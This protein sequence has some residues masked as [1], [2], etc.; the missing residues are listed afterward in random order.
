MRI[1]FRGVVH[2]TSLAKSLKRELAGHGHAVGIRTCENLVAAMAGY[3]TWHEL[4]AVCGRHPEASPSDE[5]VGAAAAAARRDQ[6]ASVLAARFGEATALSVVDAIRPTGTRAPSPAPRHAVVPYGNAAFAADRAG[7]GVPFV[8]PRPAEKVEDGCAAVAGHLAGRLLAVLEMDPSVSSIVP[9]PVAVNVAQGRRSATLVP[10]FLVRTIGGLEW[11]A[12]V[13]DPELLEPANAWI[14]DA[15][16]RAM[17]DEGHRLLVVSPDSFSAPPLHGSQ[18]AETMSR[19]LRLSPE[20]AM[21]IMRAVERAPGKAIGIRALGKALERG[22]W[23]A[24][25]PALARA[26]LP[27]SGD[28]SHFP[29]RHATACILRAVRLGFVDWD[30]ATHA[31]GIDGVV[32]PARTFSDSWS[33]IALFLPD[34][35]RA[36]HPQWFLAAHAEGKR[37]IASLPVGLRYERGGIAGVPLQSGSFK[38]DLGSLR[39]RAPSEDVTPTPR[40]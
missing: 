5:S 6:Y 11:H 40:P 9:T 34:A 8:P 2:P 21:A 25:A 37:M 3:T 22:G 35:V 38:P 33:A 20:M 19:G 14:L 30:P 27:R 23:P 24:K 32:R 7:R 39:H 4:S 31:D 16:S 15:A 29:P 10:D 26:I 13:P 12:H 17:A 1:H 36:T 28:P 18:H